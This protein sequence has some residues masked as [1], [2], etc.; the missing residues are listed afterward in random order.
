MKTII[1]VFFMIGLS[2]FTV[3]AQ[4]KAQ[5][6]KKQVEQ[7]RIDIAQD[8]TKKTFEIYASG[9]STVTKTQVA[10]PKDND[11]VHE[12]QVY[13]ADSKTFITTKQILANGKTINKEMPAAT[14][15]TT[16]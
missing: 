3:K 11:V 4:E 10:A 7:I 12:E 14:G 8:G 15:K 1:S 2:V 5:L 16:K 9:S 13:D 6:P